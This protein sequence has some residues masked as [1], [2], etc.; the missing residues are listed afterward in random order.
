MKGEELMVRKRGQMGPVAH[1]DDDNQGLARWVA[2]QPPPR[3]YPY[4]A[5][6]YGHVVENR[7]SFWG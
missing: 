1:A 3:A 5:Q 2:W 6:V 4:E 7:V